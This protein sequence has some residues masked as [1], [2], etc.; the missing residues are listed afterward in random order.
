MPSDRTQTFVTS[1]GSPHHCGPYCEHP[2]QNG[3]HEVKALSDLLDEAEEG[4]PYRVVASIDGERIGYEVRGILVS[5]KMRLHG[6]RMWWFR[7][8]VFE[9]FVDPDLIV[10]I[11]EERRRWF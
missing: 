7:H 9:H 10:D 11:E 3:V 4:K 1:D 2:G 5:K 6:V 8:Q